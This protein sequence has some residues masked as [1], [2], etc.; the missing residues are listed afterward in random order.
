[1]NE[2]LRALFQPRSIVVVG[3]SRDRHSMSGCLLSNLMDTFRGPLYAVNPNTAMIGPLRAYRSVLDITDEIEL[4][5]LA[6]PAAHVVTAGQQCAQKRVRALVVISAG[7]SE[8]DETGREREAQ[9]VEVARSGGMALVGPNCFG[10]FNTAADSGFNGTF[11]PVAPSRGNVAVCTQSGAI[12]VIIPEFFR[13]TNLGITSFVSMGNKADVAEEDL[14]PWW[15]QDPATKVIMLYLESIRAPRELLPLARRISQRKPIIVLK[16]G[17]TE[18]GARAASSHTAAMA[19]SS[20]AAEALFRQA[21]MICVADLQQLFDTAALLSNQPLPLGRRVGIVS[22]AGGPAILCTDALESRG[23]VVPEFSPALKTA[24]C[25]SLGASASVRNPIDLLASVDPAAYCTCLE[26][27]LA[28]DE[29]DAVIAIYVPRL[30]GTTPN[31]AHAV[32]EAFAASQRRKPLLAVLMDPQACTTNS[33]QQ[34]GAVP[35]YLFP[36]PAARALSHAAKYAQWSQRPEGQMV[37]FADTRPDDARQ[38]IERCLAPSEQEGRWLGVEDVAAVLEAFGLPL[39]NWETAD[40]AEAAVAAAVRLGGSVVMKALSPQLLHKWEAGGVVL[41]LRGADSVRDAYAQLS[42]LTAPSR[43][44]LIQQCIPHG[45]EVLIGVSH[46]PAFGRLIA[47]GAGGTTT[48]A[49]RDIAFRL[50][51]LTDRDAVELMFETRTVQSW[52]RKRDRRIDLD[53]LK[54]VLLRVSA[55]IDALPEIVEMDLNPIKVLDGGE[56][57]TVVDARIRVAPF[58]KAP[59]VA[60]ARQSTLPSRRPALPLTFGVRPNSPP[61]RPTT[62][63]SCPDLGS[64]LP[65]RG[66]DEDVRDRADFERRDRLAS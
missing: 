53:A 18:A 35:G 33:F 39:P 36:E 24:L 10:V 7:F 21:G 2:S 40:S 13:S 27:L 60:N 46:E 48:E 16:A 66:S 3:A 44:V 61:T 51:P 58:P 43:R 14:L 31:V 26:M 25:D 29:V 4:A 8:T 59:E 30:K 20:I 54:T 41:G 57:L 12:G 65:D 22:N 38:V 6:V 52:D 19:G 9:L 42:A 56:R 23:L 45:R 5:F 32:Q 11:S 34:P 64:P 50:H 1:M 62:W 15:E 49:V 37:A 17:N 55:M 47:F 28:S 63:T